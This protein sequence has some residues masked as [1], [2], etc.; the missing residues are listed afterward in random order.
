MLCVCDGI[1]DDI[2]QEDLQYAS[3][4]LVDETADS[5]HT[6]SA[7]KT[8]DSWFGDTLDVVTKYFPVTLG[9]SLSKTLASFSAARHVEIVRCGVM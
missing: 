7:S 1:S 8:T 5:L 4:F 6:T 3:G 2:F 9:A